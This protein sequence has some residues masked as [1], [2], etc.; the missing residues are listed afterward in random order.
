MG[1]RTQRIDSLEFRSRTEISN[2]I[3][4]LFG[5]AK[6]GASSFFNLHILASGAT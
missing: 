5:P 1:F 6:K 3:I 2:I 4:D